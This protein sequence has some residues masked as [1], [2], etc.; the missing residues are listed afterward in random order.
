[1][2]QP[3]VST[4]SILNSGIFQCPCYLVLL[5]LVGILLTDNSDSALHTQLW[6]DP[7]EKFLQYTH[8]DDAVDVSFGMKELK[9]CI[10]GSL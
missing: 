7:A 10:V 3:K 5:E 2:T 8:V 1:M 9:V 4:L 6:I